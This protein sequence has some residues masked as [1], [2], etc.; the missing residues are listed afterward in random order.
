MLAHSAF[1]LRLLL[2]LRRGRVSDRGVDP[3]LIALGAPVGI[4]CY[5]MVLVKPGLVEG[6]S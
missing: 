5:E 2:V 3:K 1:D 4:C 6:L